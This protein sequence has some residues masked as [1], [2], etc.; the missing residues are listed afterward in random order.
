MERSPASSFVRQTELDQTVFAVVDV[1][2]TGFSA[3][4]DRVVEVACVRMQGGRIIDRFSTIVDPEREI[5]PYATNVHGITDDDVAGKPTLGEVRGYLGDLV[6]D[7]AIVAHNASFD[8][9]FLP[10][11]AHR[12]VV[13]SMRLAMHVYDAPRYTNQALRAALCA[14]DRDLRDLEAHRA[15]ADAIVTAHVFRRLL[16]FYHA[17]GHPPTL[18]GMIE[19]I[20]RRASRTRFTSRT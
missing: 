4:T 16:D 13:C 17:A 3:F 1:E 18:A 11:V 14:N 20:S 9:S 8:M 7:A 19:T 12:P 15:L 6:S 10:F 2:T 5:P